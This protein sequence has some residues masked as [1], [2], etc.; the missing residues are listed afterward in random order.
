[1]SSQE[2]IDPKP[3]PD[4]PSCVASDTPETPTT[5]HSSDGLISEFRSL[6]FP[7]GNAADAAD[8]L[9]VEPIDSSPMDES[10]ELSL[11]PLY[12]QHNTIASRL[13]TTVKSLRMQQLHALLR[14]LGVPVDLE[15]SELALLL[16]AARRARIS[17]CVQ[18]EALKA[19]SDGPNAILPH[20]LAV[21][22]IDTLVRALDSDAT[23]SSATEASDEEDPKSSSTT[24]NQNLQRL[25]V[26]VCVCVV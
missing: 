5:H 22:Q 1:M 15:G 12:G 24:V 18:I 7:S 14:R 4:G 17:T 16:K 19:Q 21:E 2:G 25:V 13:K 3:S 20:K 11:E 26:C 8:V 10:G 23:E 6:L 9:E